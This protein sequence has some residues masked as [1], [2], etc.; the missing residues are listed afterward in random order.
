[1]INYSTRHKLNL[2]L[3]FFF[4]TVRRVRDYKDFVPWC[5]DSYETN[6]H[7]KHLSYESIAGKYPQLIH[8]KNSHA[9]IKDFFNF[10]KTHSA[11][12]SSPSHLKVRNFEGTITVG[13]N[14]LDFS[15]TSHVVAIEPNLILS[16]S[17]SSKSQ[18]FKKLESLWIITEDKEDASQIHIE[19]HINFEFKSYMFS[20]VTNLFLD[21]LGENIVKAFIEKTKEESDKFSLVEEKLSEMDL[22]EVIDSKLSK[23][24]FESQSDKVTLSLLINK[25]YEMKQLSLKEIEVLLRIIKHNLN[26]RRR[27]IFL[28]DIAVWNNQIQV[29][30][31]KEE[32]KRGIYL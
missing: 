14:I 12:K 6:K 5:K 2:P 30:K 10:N 17:D 25:L 19:Y 18:I 15:Y 21:F 28:S 24:H 23:I 32:I 3:K 31:I 13:F 7:T 20:H 29:E 27:L 9:I 11:D 22:N 26:F 16:V 4:N 8:N 1:M